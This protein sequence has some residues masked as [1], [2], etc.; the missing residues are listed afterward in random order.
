MLCVFEVLVPV[1]I[2]DWEAYQGYAY[3]YYWSNIRRSFLDD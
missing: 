1:A 2:W 3:T